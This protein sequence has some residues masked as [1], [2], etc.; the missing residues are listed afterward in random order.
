MNSVGIYGGTFNPIHS[1]HIKTAEEVL[2]LRK[3][4]KIIYIPCF[5]SPHK[6]NFKS[7]SAEHR[8]KMVQLAIKNN[9][10]FSISD[11]EIQ[12][13]K[14]SYTYETIL[15]LKKQYE[16]IELIIGYDNMLSFN[17]WK[18]P[19]LILQNAKVIVLR[20][21][22]SIS[23]KIEHNFDKSMIFLKTSYYQ[24]SSTD[25]RE[26]LNKGLPINNLVPKS[27]MKYIYN[28]N[29]YKE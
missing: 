2:Q 11:I 1:G 23:T 28:L 14:V 24:I 3:L 9:K 17:K 16:N 29:L 15:E 8:F 13:E 27:V 21:M 22:E 20:R 5:I 6:K 26:R 10:N 4:D 25:I 19:D 18:Y 7:V 12:K